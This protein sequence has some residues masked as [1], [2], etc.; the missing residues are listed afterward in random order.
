VALNAPAAWGDA[1]GC[2]AS[3]GGAPRS[4]PRAVKNPIPRT[5]R[6]PR[7]SRHRTTEAPARLELGSFFQLY[8]S[9]SSCLPFEKSGLPSFT[10]ALRARVTNGATNFGQTRLA[11]RNRAKTFCRWD[12]LLRVRA[13]QRALNRAAPSLDAINS[14]QRHR[15]HRGIAE[16]RNHFWDF[17]V[18]LWPLRLYSI[19]W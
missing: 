12:V 8:S 18:S 16:N 17:S 4:A 6:P 1:Q 13:A 7:G 14:T 10:G 9:A 15:E 5:R 19:L 3:T 2:I 11:A